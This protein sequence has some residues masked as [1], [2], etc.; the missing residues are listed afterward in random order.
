MT[1]RGTSF[2]QNITQNVNQ[3]VVIRSRYINECCH[4]LLFSF[5]R[6]MYIRCKQRQSIPCPSAF[7][8]IILASP[9]SQPTNQTSWTHH[10]SARDTDW[11]QNLEQFSMQNLVAKNLGCNLSQSE[12]EIPGVSLPFSRCQSVAFRISYCTFSTHDSIFFF[13]LHA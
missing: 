4:R 5:K 6:G 9:F 8:K 3:D 11:G 13:I 7:S 2:S 10:H 1:C 12:T